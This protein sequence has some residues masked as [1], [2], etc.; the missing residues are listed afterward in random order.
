M[1][2][3][4]LIDYNR[5]G[6][7]ERNE[8]VI[9]KDYTEICYVGVDPNPP[10]YST[11][12]NIAAFCETHNCDLITGDKRAYA[13]FLENSHVKAVQISLYGHDEDANQQIYL[14]KIL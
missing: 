1:T 14:I 10:R 11:D 13:N 12:S 7:A 4:V 6:W 8:S 3:K 9:K 2:H 5:K